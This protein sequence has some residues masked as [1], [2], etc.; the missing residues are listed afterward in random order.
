[1]SENDVRTRATGWLVVASEVML[2]GV[3]LVVA[4]AAVAAALG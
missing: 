3:G 4:G 1:M 2:A